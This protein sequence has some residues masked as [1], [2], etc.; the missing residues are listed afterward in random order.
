MVGIFGQ[1]DYFGEEFKKVVTLTP[2]GAVKDILIA[3]LEPV[4]WNNH[5]TTALLLTL[6]YTVVF[7]TLGI[8]WFKWNTH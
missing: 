3:S 4:K 2:Y 6:G 7:A 5:T 8:K 1:F